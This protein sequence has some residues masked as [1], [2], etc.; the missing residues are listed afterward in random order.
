[1]AILNYTTKIDYHKT[2]GEITKVLVKHGAKKI[3]IDYDNDQFPSS[4][5][6][7]IVLNN[8]EVVFQLPARYNGVLGAMKKQKVPNNYCNKEQSVRVAWRI[9]KDW[10]ESQMAIVESEISEVSEVFLPYAL[11]NNGQTV[12]EKIKESGTK[13]LLLK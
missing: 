11:L 10:V 4:L 13:F 12:F 3:M 6:F 8:L 1:M 5:T 7:T 9:I 2:I